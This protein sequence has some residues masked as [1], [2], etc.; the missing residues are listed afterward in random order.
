MLKG[1]G[2]PWWHIG[3]RISCCHCWG[4]GS[5]AQELPHAVGMAKTTT[6][7]QHQSCSLGSLQPGRG[8]TPESDR[9]GTQSWTSTLQKCLMS[10]MP[11]LW[12]FVMAAG[13]ASDKQYN[14]SA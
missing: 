10:K 3:L 6:T 9:I 5:L 1:Q 12:D 11:R 2:V 14:P 8:L 13:A 7:T 4:M